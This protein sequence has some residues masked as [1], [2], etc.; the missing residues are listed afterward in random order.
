VERAN[1]IKLKDEFNILEEQKK[2]TIVPLS[3]TVINVEQEIRIEG[4]EQNKNSYF[5]HELT[6]HTLRY[7]DSRYKIM[8]TVLYRWVCNTRKGFSRGKNIL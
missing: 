5:E 4:I 6:A 2:I 1:E 7:I 8:D 3:N